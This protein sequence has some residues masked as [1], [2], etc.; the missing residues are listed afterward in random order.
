MTLIHL[1]VVRQWPYRH[2]S[3]TKRF[4]LSQNAHRLDLSPALQVDER[5]NV[6]AAVAV[7]HSNGEVLIHRLSKRNTS[8]L[9]LCSVE[10]SGHLRANP[11]SSSR[12]PRLFGDRRQDGGSFH[13]ESAVDSRTL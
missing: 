9:G 2:R 5:G 6:L 11:E 4:M 12:A 1:L 7:A 8:L 3:P 13:L 10:R